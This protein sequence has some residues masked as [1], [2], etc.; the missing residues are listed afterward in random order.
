MQKRGT[1]NHNI[2]MNTFIPKYQDVLLLTAVYFST[3]PFVFLCII[4]KTDHSEKFFNRE[5]E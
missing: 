4:L 1:R 5:A 3:N 2:Y